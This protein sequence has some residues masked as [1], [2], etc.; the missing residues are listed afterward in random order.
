MHIHTLR[1]TVTVPS[2]RYAVPPRHGFPSRG[3]CTLMRTEFPRGTS[4]RPCPRP[5]H[6]RHQSCW[7]P[8]QAACCGTVNIATVQICVRRQLFQWRTSFCCSRSASRTARPS[9]S[10]SE[11]SGERARQSR[12]GVCVAHT[13]SHSSHGRH[14]Q[15]LAERAATELAAAPSI[16]CSGQKSPPF[17]APELPSSFS[18]ST[19]GGQSDFAWCFP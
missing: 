19:G 4:M 8:A 10:G 16:A 9:D 13:S 2:S 6:S 18:A 14:A 11:F 17:P 15:S 12:F 3:S 7:N 1:Q 5:C